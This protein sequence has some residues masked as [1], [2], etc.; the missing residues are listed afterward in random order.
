MEPN[1]PL[2]SRQ[3]EV[4][5]MPLNLP[6]TKSPLSEKGD[7]EARVNNMAIP[8]LTINS[9]CNSSSSPLSLLTPTSKNADIEARVSDVALSQLI[10]PSSLSPFPLSPS[11]PPFSD[12]ILKFIATDIDTA[13]TLQAPNPLPNEPKLVSETPIN[14]PNYILPATP[15]L[16]EEE[17]I[18]LSGLKKFG[19]WTDLPP[20][21]K[22]TLTSLL[23]AEEIAILKK[24]RPQIRECLIR[25][26]N[27]S[28]NAASNNVPSVDNSSPAA[29]SSK[30]SPPL[31]STNELRQQNLHG[32]LKTRRFFPANEEDYQ[33]FLKKNNL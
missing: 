5:G 23:T 14:F 9:P 27:Q 22:I 6:S 7:R 32:A 10:I 17:Q 21:S 16:S 28:N 3:A 31:L 30:V 20:K 19:E 4:I 29:S 1:L 13:M 33:D 12:E 2:F 24:T 18:E 8:P 11:A 15:I 25:E 26:E